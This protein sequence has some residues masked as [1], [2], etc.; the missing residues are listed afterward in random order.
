MI[1]GEP[2]YTKDL[3]IVIGTDSEELVAFRNALQQFGFPM[4]DEA[5]KE[6]A[7]PNRMV[8]IGHPPARIDFLNQLKGVEFST[9]WENRTILPIDGI[10]VCFISLPDLIVSKRAT[11]RPQDLIDLKNLESI[12]G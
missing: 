5:V 10:D 2:R 7:E 6:L 3:D 11:G 12:K 8:K 4:S 1:Y 9:A